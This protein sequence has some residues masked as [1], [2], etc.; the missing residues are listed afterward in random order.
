MKLFCREGGLVASDFTIRPATLEDAHRIGVISPVAFALAY[1]DSWADDAALAEHLETFGHHAWTDFLQ[2][3]DT[4]AWVVEI[5]GRVTGVLSMIAGSC[6]P[7]TTQPRGA[8]I[9]RIYLLP[10]TRSRGAGYALLKTA[11]AKARELGL[12]YVWLD[13]MA[14]ADWAIAAY[15]RWG[16]TTIGEEQ[17][18]KKLKPGLNRMLVMTKSLETES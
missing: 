17:F 14:F 12:A 11:E 13:V 1:A 16:F 3:D 9:P 8:E 7:V 18:P 5:A 15:S 4:H 6:E 2:R 10:G